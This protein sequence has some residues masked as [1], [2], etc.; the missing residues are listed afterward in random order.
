LPAFRRPDGFHEGPAL[1]PAQRAAAESLIAHL[2]DGS[3]TLL[4]GVTGSGKTEVYFEAVA[5]TLRAGRQALVLLP[6]IALTGQWLERFEQ[7]F[8]ARPAEWHSDLTGAE[9]RVAWRAIAMGEAR[10]VVGARSALFLPFPD[11]GLVIV[12]EEH[13]QAYKQE[14]G[15][16]YQ[17]RDMAVLR[18]H[19]AR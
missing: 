7:R 2:A 15:V 19:L 13:E 1:S 4:D 17:A 16:A 6:E 14:D 5:A 8:G 3:V 10:V 11:L 18:G 9:R 12:D